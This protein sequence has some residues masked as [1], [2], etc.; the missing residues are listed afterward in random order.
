MK[1][2]I[3]SLDFCYSGETETI[4]VQV[5]I[6]NFQSFYRD[7]SLALNDGFVE[8]GG[9]IKSFFGSREKVFFII[10]TIIRNSCRNASPSAPWS[11]RTTLGQRERTRCS[12]FSTPF[13]L[14]FSSRLFRIRKQRFEQRWQKCLKYE[15]GTSYQ[16]GGRIP[17]PVTKVTKMILLVH[18]LIG[19]MI[20]HLNQF[21]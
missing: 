14:S 12:P 20:N 21:Q 18:P 7:H 1:R 8:D 6:L 17:L 2:P 3:S 13:S 5:K 16:Q 4:S 15:N 9:S 19:Q 11:L 10:T